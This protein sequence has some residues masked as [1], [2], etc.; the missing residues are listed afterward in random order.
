MQG[1][2]CMVDGQDIPIKNDTGAL[3]LHRLQGQLCY[4]DWS[5]SM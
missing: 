3:L 5:L 2:G 4:E 1:P